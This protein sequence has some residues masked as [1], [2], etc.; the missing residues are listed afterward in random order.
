MKLLIIAIAALG[1]SSQWSRAD[2]AARDRL[3]KAIDG[4]LEIAQKGAANYPENR[5]CFSC[6]HQSLPMLAMAEARIGCLPN[7]A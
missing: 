2:E 6:H 4:G 1:F 3:Q 5:S 7:T